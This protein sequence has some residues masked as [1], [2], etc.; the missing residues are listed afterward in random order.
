VLVVRDELWS[1]RIPPEVAA[2]LGYFWTMNDE[3]KLAIAL[4]RLSV[5]GPLVS[6]RLEHGDCLALFEETC[7]EADWR[8]DGRL[9]RLSPRT[10]E[11]WFYAYRQAGL[12]GLKPVSVQPGVHG[13]GQAV[14]A[15]VSVQ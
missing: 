12:E 14:S 2:G 4:W 10:I 13:G 5:L 9:V 6:A 15:R 3:A 7:P 8:P 11:S 1:Q